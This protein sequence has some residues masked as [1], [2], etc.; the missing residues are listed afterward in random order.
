MKALAFWIKLS[1]ETQIPIRIYA[2]IWQRRFHQGNA[3][4]ISHQAVDELSKNEEFSGIKIEHLSN[5][6]NLLF[7]RARITLRYKLLSWKPYL[8]A[9]Y[10][11]QIHHVG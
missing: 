1:D 10:L 5:R 2:R 7:N 9:E 4:M 11:C 8:T 6:T 3:V